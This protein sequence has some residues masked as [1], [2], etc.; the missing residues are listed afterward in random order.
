MNSS[1]YQIEIKASYL[2]LLLLKDDLEYF[3]NRINSFELVDHYS[4]VGLLRNTRYIFIIL[5]NIRDVS[6]KLNLKGSK[7]YINKTRKIRK[8]L[9]FAKHFRHKVAGHLDKIVSE[10]A[11]QWSPEL[12]HNERKNNKDLQVFECHKVIIESAINSFINERGE[13]KIFGK[14]IDLLSPTD[15]KNF[16]KYLWEIGAD[17]IEWVSLSL[18]IIESEIIYLD[19]NE[20]LESLSIAAKTEFNLKKES[21]FIYDKDESMASLQ[22]TLKELKKLGASQEVIDYIGSGI[23]KMI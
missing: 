16:Y 6:E 5:N 23:I 19:D 2:N 21:N 7:E 20:M 10:R 11:V 22:N 13:Q 14:E 1:K 9:L 12:F 4:L 3:H 8:S 17:S 18:S 15:S